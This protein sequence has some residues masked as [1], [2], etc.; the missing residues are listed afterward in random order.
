MLNVRFSFAGVYFVPYATCAYGVARLLGC[1]ASGKVLKYISTTL[2]FVVTMVIEIVIIILLLLWKPSTDAQSELWLYILIPIGIG[3]V[4][5]PPTA[6]L[7]SIYGKF[8]VENKKAGTALLGVWNPL[9]SAI[10]FGLSGVLYPIDMVILVLV[11]GIVGTIFFVL[12][13]HMIDKPNRK[14]SCVCAK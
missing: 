2:L 14:F 5:S 3:L 13:E 7:G 8:F 4:Q 10:C 6:Q 9:G 12:A 11:T 1:Y